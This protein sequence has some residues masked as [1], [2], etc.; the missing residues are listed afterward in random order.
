MAC[1]ASLSRGFGVVW[2]AG[3][4]LSRCRIQLRDRPTRLA[5]IC[6]FTPIATR[7]RYSQRASHAAGFLVFRSKTDISGHSITTCSHF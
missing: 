1:Q 7:R 5:A 3:V 4:D 2:S 6:F